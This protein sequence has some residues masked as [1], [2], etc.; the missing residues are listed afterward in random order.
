M[1]LRMA[2]MSDVQLGVTIRQIRHADFFAAILQNVIDA[3]KVERRQIFAVR[4]AWAILHR[5]TDAD[6]L[7]HTAVIWRNLFIGQRP[8]SAES[9]QARSAKVYVAET[10]G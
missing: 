1:A 8:V 3:T 5:A 6:H 2:F 7:L 4:V 9:I 10:R